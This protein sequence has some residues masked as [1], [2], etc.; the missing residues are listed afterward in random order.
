MKSCVFT[1]NFF[2]IVNYL[3]DPLY[4]NEAKFPTRDL[5]TVSV[6]KILGNILACSTDPNSFHNQNL[7]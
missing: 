2:G 5:F 3:F 4:A 6:M 7:N 1:K